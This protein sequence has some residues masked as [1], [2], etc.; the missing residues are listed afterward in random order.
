MA[1]EVKTYNFN[2]KTNSTKRPLETDVIDTFNA[3]VLKEQC[4]IITPAIKIN[5]GVTALTI[6]NYVYIPIW[7]RYYFVTDIQWER[8]LWTMR[9][10]VDALA[11]WKTEIGL[12]S[13][14]VTRCAQRYDGNIMDNLYPAKSTPVYTNVINDS[15][16]ETTNLQNGMFVVGVAGQNTTYYKF[17]YGA[18]Q[19]FLEYILGDLYAQELTDNWASVFTSLNWE[20]NP[21]Q[22]IVSINWF[23]F[24]TTVTGTSSIR[25]GFVD[26]PVSASEV[27]GSGLVF[28]SLTLTPPEHPQASF[29]G[30][31]LN[32]APYSSYDLFYPP[33]GQIQLDPTLIANTDSLDLLVGV[34]LRTGKGTLTILDND[35]TVLTSWIHAQV[36][37]PYQTTQIMTQGTF[38]LSK[39]VGMVGSMA[40]A[41]ATGNPMVAGTSLISNSV[42]ALGD[43]ARGKIPSSRTIG[44][45]GGMNALRGSITL[46]CEFKQLVSEDN[47]SRGRPYCQT[48]QINEL[49]GY[50]LVSDA[51][52][53][54]PA[55]EAENQEIRSYMEGGFFYE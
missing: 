43:Y 23:P 40:P 12:Q 34:D 36:S 53:E 27:D 44:S 30:S 42:S 29:R 15:A 18:L 8:G 54:I 10:T 49:S 35:N 6:P 39:A 14:Y 11:S 4:S 33:F 20:A 52:I 31:Y 22:Y 16:W 1:F 46:Q 38:D 55:M 5:V 47:T 45:N 41:M 21:L 7:N 26:V 24:S 2:K 25:V 50:I 9:L 17:S 13:L 19:L 51:D 48:V 37:L 32:N 3:T 28:F